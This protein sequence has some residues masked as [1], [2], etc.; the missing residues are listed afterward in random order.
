MTKREA[1]PTKPQHLIW[2]LIFA[3]G[4][5]GFAW[6]VFQIPGADGDDA[7]SGPMSQEDIDLSVARRACRD[8]IG[9]QLHDPDSAEWGNVALWPAGFE[10]GRDDRILVQPEIRARNA[11]GG[12]IL[13]RFQC[14]FE[15]SGD[16]MRLVNLGE[17]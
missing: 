7:V 3:A 6:S 12:L 1:D 14:T 2:P 15:G 5:I 8:V 17:Y 4:A 10:E 13:T 11:M 16:E 9:G